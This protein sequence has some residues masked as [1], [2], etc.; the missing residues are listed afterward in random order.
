MIRNYLFTFLPLLILTFT[1]CEK[2][3][4]EDN[5][6][7]YFGGEI[8]NPQSK[9]VLFLK[10]DKIIDTIFLDK[11]NRFLHK[12]DSLTPG[13]YTFKHLPEYQ[14]VFFDKNDSLMIRLNSFDFDNSLSFCGRGEEKNNFL[15]DLY[16]KNEK[17]RTTLYDVLDKEI[18]PFT[19]N[20]DSVYNIRKSYYLK[21]KA[22]I[23]W[24][25]SF[26]KVA[27]AGLDFHHY[28]KKEL[29]PYAHKYKTGHDISKSIPENFYDYRKK[30]SYNNPELANFSPF[31]KYINIMLS[32]V[33]YDTNNGLYEE[34]SL[35]NNII[36]LNI[37]DTLISNKNIKN[38]VFNNIAYMYLLED[39][40]MYN[41]KKFI[42]RYLTLS[43]DEEQQKEVKQIYNA[44]KNLNQGNKLP[45]IKLIDA[46]LNQISL[47][48][49]LLN[50]ET[51]L[52]FWTSQ[53][54]SHLK[55]VHKRVHDYQKKFPNVNFIAINVDDTNETWMKTKSKFDM[56]NITELRAANF[57]EIKR[58]WVITKI[59]RTI[60][61]S[62]EGTIKKG[63][64][65]LFDVN[66]EKDLN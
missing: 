9:F 63:F 51:V 43:T 22:E 4:D 20:I 25:T 32:N 8:I 48:S 56:S 50:K 61:L 59:H 13:L 1:S 27:Q 57:E 60:I 36:K 14:Y 53:A 21:K 23:N 19:K 15:I 42:D 46:D 58:L 18:E 31:I 17:D 10:D 45:E 16:L 35:E 52:F 40:N 65:N 12:F 6:E 24:S 55:Y 38:I 30:I 11:N 64:A 49:K 29:Y 7:A 33:S 37:A 2:G 66:F 54:E 47:D 44:V 39:Q 5:F 3:F 62:K 34:L 26:D 41:N 28:Y